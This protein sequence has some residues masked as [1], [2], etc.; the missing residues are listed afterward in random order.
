MN[1]HRLDRPEAVVYE[2]P[3]GIA[4]WPR[5]SLWF[6]V[7]LLVVEACRI[8]SPTPYW[9]EAHGHAQG[10]RIAG[11]SGGVLLLNGSQQLSAYPGHWNDPWLAQPS[12]RALRA[13]TAA[14]TV[15]FGL[16]TDGRLLRFA[17]QHWSTREGVERA[18]NVTEI[19]ATEDNRLLVL[20]DGKLM[21]LNDRTL[22]DLGCDSVAGV[23]ISGGAEHESFVVDRDGGL[24]LS[25]A[26]HCDPIATPTP[27][28]RIAGHADR[29]LAVAANGSVWR[30][31]QGSWT[32]LPLP[33][34]YRPGQSAKKTH[35]AD[36]ALSA[37]S[38]WL[39]D[40]E[41]SVFLLS[42]ET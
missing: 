30:R 41:G 12:T 13:V 40:D 9:I 29:L 23:A 2:L 17:D 33:L 10:S 20:A 28:R 14:A 7:L 3:V 32:Q 21:Q 38:T 25:T 24:Y 36:V 16:S 31:R 19:A 4:M 26:G 39:L 18:K 37:Y 11:W 1:V 5:G 42:D 27:L 8:R 15:A 22:E 6:G 34:K 35:A